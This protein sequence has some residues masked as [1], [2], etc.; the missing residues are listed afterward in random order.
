LIHDLGALSENTLS[1]LALTATRRFVPMA[2]RKV[3]VFPAR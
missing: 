2:G 1:S 3:C